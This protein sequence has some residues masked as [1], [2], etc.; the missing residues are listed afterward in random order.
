MKGTESLQKNI[1]DIPGNNHFE[2]S[3]R[4]DKFAAPNL[5]SP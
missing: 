5:C 3:Q 4:K 2:R 1:A